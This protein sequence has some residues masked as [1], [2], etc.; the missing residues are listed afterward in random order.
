MR[1]ISHMLLVVLA[2]LAAGYLSSADAR[3]KSDLK[4]ILQVTIDGLRADLLNRYRKGFG[5]GGFRYLMQQGVVYT[6]AHYQHANTETI[7]GHATLATG[8]FPSEHGMI[9]NVWFDREAGELAYNIEDP[10]HPLLPTREGQVQGEQV[11]PAQK[12]S[13]TQGRSPVS[14][15]AATLGDG[16][17]AYYGGQS[18]VFGVSG[19]DRSAVSMAGQTG[20][21]FWYSTDTGDFVT[22]TYYYDAYPGWVRDW[23]AQ[24]KAESYAG[25]SWRLLNDAAT[26]LLGHQDDRAYE[27]DLRGYG[28]VFPHPFGKA[29]DKLFYTRLLVR[30]VGDQLIL[31][32]SKA[33]PDYLSISFSSVD[34]VNHFFGPSSLE[35]EDIVLQLDRTLADLFAFVDET[36]GLKYTLIVLSADHGMADMPEYMTE[37]GFAA[38]RL[39]PDDV[40]KV[41]NEAG[42]RLFGINEVVASSSALICIWTTKKSRPPNW[43][44]QRSSRV[45]PLH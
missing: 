44:I 21:A 40:I 11:D 43:T 28:R 13:R 34:A 17:K 8:A 7:V 38:G 16:L 19:K 27:V 3:T 6:N 24:R 15:L 5:K 12:L 37:L 36:V 35:N 33:L 22:S 39:Y 25:S 29:A 42:K 2:L 9:G 26:Y 20:R 41:A 45:A 31:D 1:H 10:Q 23:N 18:K 4:L 14:I 32:F 30:P